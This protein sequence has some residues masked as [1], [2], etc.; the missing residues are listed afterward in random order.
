[1]LKDSC[2]ISDNVSDKEISKMMML[3]SGSPTIMRGLLAERL[4]RSISESKMCKWLKHT[5]LANDMRIIREKQKA[6][7]VKMRD[8]REGRCPPPEGEDWVL[9]PSHS[10]K[11]YR[12]NME[13]YELWTP[14]QRKLVQPFLLNKTYPAYSINIAKNKRY[15]ITVCRLFQLCLDGKKA[16]SNKIR[17]N[18]V[19]GLIV[20]QPD[21][22]DPDSSF[23]MVN[24]YSC[25]QVKSN[26]AKML[27]I[28]YGKHERPTTSTPPT[29][30]EF[31]CL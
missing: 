17:W 15:V 29:L 24:P 31:S 4:G 21:P 25:D 2:I 28:K 7:M 22:F 3:S 5:G 26:A 13:T 20:R 16:G 18:D 19:Q 27:N 8:I 30:S 9:I 14:H 23:W 10:Q 11:H 12:F 6:L 1:M